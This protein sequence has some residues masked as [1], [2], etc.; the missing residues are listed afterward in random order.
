MAAVGG[1]LS[2]LS[3]E[4]VKTDTKASLNHVFTK[5]KLKCYCIHVQFYSV[6]TLTWI[7]EQNTATVGS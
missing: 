2:S 6:A 4:V 5:D 7:I 3:Q 1:G